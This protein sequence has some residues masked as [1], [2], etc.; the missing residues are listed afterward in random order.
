MLDDTHLR[1][2]TREGLEKLF[3]DAGFTVGELKRTAAEILDTEVKVDLE[4]V[5]EEALKMIQNVSESETYQF[6]LMGYSSGYAERFRDL[7]SRVHL[8]SEKL[9]QRDRVIYDLNRRLRNLEE[10]ER[11]LGDRD[12]RL[13]AK[14][15][16]VTELTQ[17]LAERNHE[18]ADSKRT[19]SKLSK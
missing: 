1:F 16:E 13:A 10:L 6:V 12:R 9:E 17:R 5:P 11:R 4:A 2:F 19:V 3:N 7:S 14:E 8:L 18:L 15:K